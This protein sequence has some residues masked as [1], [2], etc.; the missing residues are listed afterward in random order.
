LLYRTLT[1][2]S[3]RLHAGVNFY[4]Y[5]RPTLTRLASTAGFE[6]IESHPESMPTS[7]NRFT[8]LARDAYDITSGAFYRVT[9]GRWN[10][11]AKELCIFQKP[12][13]QRISA[14]TSTTANRQPVSL[15]AG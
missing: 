3:L 15:R 10:F 7:G 1:G 12:H 9:N 5:T 6:F 11:S 13:A 2:Q 4:F 14:S 8:Q